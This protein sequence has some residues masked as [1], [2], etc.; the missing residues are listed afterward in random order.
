MFGRA[1]HEAVLAAGEPESGA[2]VHLA[3][4]GYDTGPIVASRRVPVL[5]GDTPEALAARVLAAEHLLYPETVD[6][7][8]RREVDLDAIAA[9]H[10]K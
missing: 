8:A 4:G 10:Q 7:I 6:R 5:A 9:D 1:V 2:T 3:D